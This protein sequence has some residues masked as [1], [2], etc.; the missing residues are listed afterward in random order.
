[1]YC[2]K[3]YLFG[4][5]HFVIA[6]RMMKYCRVVEVEVKLLYICSVGAQLSFKTAK[7]TGCVTDWH[8]K[9]TASEFWS[10]DKEVK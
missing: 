5:I 2:E 4:R 1:M 9:N 7:K 6:L 10:S 8:E 3:I